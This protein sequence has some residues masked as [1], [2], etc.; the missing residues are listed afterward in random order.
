MR[1]ATVVTARLGSSRMPRKMFADLGG[2]TV[3]ERLVERLRLAIE[4]DMMLMATTVEAEDDELEAAAPPSVSPSSGGRPATSSSAGAW[5]RR[6]T[7]S[8]C[9]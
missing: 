6:P 3:L 4:P 1:S 7:T 9:S 8:I 5:Q 2:Q